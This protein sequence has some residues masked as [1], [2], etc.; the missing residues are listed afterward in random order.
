VEVARKDLIILIKAS[1]LPPLT[2]RVITKENL[3]EKE[4]RQFEFDTKFRKGEVKE[5]K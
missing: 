2:E 4:R 3:I 1:L 5:K